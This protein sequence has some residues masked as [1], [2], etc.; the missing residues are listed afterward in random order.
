VNLFENQVRA[1]ATA[2]E[3]VSASRLDRKALQK[4]LLCD[5]PEADSKQHRLRCA[6]R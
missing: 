3:A 5:E 4:E 2:H 6:A 1:V